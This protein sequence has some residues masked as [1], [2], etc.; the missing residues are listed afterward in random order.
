MRPVKLIVSAFGPYAGRVEIDMAALGDRGLYLITGDTGAGK[1]TLFDAITFALYGESSGQER[2]STM[3]RSKYADAATPT[4]VELTFLYGGQEY[5]VRRNPAY[6][7]P[8]QRGAGTTTESADAE[9]RLPDGGIVTRYGDVTRRITELLGVNKDQFCQIAMLAQGDFLKLLLANTAQRQEHFRT[10]FRTGVYQLFQARLK[11]ELARINRERAKA[12]DAVALYMQS[13]ACAGDD[14]LAGEVE[15]ARRGELPVADAADLLERLI[16]RDEEALSALDAGI[17]KANGEMEA[18]A[19]LIARAETHQ[20]LCLERDE[21]RRALD[22]MV[23]RQEELRRALEAHQD[24]IVHAE[25]MEREALT[26][27]ADMKG[28]EA[29]DAL[30]ADVKTAEEDLASSRERQEKARDAITQWQD[31]LGEQKRE[32]EALSDAGERRERLKGESD[33]LEARERELKVLQSQRDAVS[34]MQAEYDAALRRFEEAQSE[35]LRLNDSAVKLRCAFNSEQAGI[36]A[37]ALRPGEPCPVCGSREHPQV[38]V[39]T[40]GAPSEA[41]VERAEKRARDAGDAANGASRAA[42]VAQGSL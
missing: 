32:H 25:A 27:E 39:L 42:A 1:T 29:L 20:K 22:E 17:G 24:S 38:A 13:M 9:L 23:P 4:E 30:R 28:Y 26:L 33:R 11:D 19:V 6:E 7:R 16:V 2:K 21:K 15:A 10:L 5:T 35:A 41:E 18:L 37:Q 14:P 36:M 12:K 3:L 8:K 34:R 31:A 40:S